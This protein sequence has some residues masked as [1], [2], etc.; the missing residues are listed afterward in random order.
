MVLKDGQIVEQGS[1]KELLAQ[2][3]VFATMWADQIS[4]NGDPSVSIGSKREGVSGYLEDEPEAEPNGAVKDEVPVSNIINTPEQTSGAFEPVDIDAPAVPAKE[5]KE[6]PPEG[7][8]APLSFPANSAGDDRQPT[9]ASGG[10]TFADSSPPSRT[11]TPDPDAEPKRKRISSQNLSR[12]ARKMSLATRRPTASS[13]TGDGTPAPQEGSEATPRE[14]LD[15]PDASI[16]GDKSKK[17]DKKKRRS[18]F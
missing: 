7:R 18:I 11:G 8:T 16:Q 15:S 12:L 13:S 9:D 3:G 1:H 4:A 2:D 17:Q 6:E 10:I 5:S 14:S